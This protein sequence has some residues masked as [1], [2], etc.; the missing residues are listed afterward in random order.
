MYGRHHCDL[1]T[2]RF[3]DLINQEKILE[4]YREFRNLPFHGDILPNIAAEKNLL[5][6]LI[7]T[8]SLNCNMNTEKIFLLTSCSEHI[9]TGCIE[10]SY[11]IISPIGWACYHKNLEMLKFLIDSDVDLFHKSKLTT[12]NNPL[13]IAIENGFYEGVKL[14][15]TN[16]LKYTNR[17]TGFL[18]TLDKLLQDFTIIAFNREIQIPFQIETVQIVDFLLSY[19]QNRYESF[20]GDAH[21]GF[22]RYIKKRLFVHIR[23]SFLKSYSNI[24][25]LYSVEKTEKGDIVWTNSLSRRE[26]RNYLQNF[27]K[28]SLLY[29]ILCN[30]DLTK[31]IAGYI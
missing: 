18:V 4:L 15:I 1:M 19:P 20:L 24:P 3:I 31:I 8:K 7:F 12:I 30:E 6:I 5:E 22:L 16:G 26:T 27:K 25:R 28:I 11:S 2:H 9:K 14:L 21:Q 10:V 29:K 17:N 23:H 13:F